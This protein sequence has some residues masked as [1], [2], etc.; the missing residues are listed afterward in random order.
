MV[1]FVF[2]RVRTVNIHVHLEML[3]IGLITG[4]CHQSLKSVNVVALSELSS[5]ST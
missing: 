1:P 3:N 4:Y 2:V 5:L